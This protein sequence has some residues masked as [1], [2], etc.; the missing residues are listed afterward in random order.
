[1]YKQHSILNT[2]NFNAD[3]KLLTDNRYSMLNGHFLRQIP[4]SSFESIF[5]MTDMCNIAVNRNRKCFASVALLLNNEKKTTCHIL[6]Y[7]MYLL[8]QFRRYMAG[9][10]LIR[11]K[12]Q[13][14]QSIN[15]SK[16]TLIHMLPYK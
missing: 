10:L 14:N 11:R 6:M 2:G 15:L 12:T 8:N 4:P 9:I 3:F 7:L 5:N 13:N 1:M 16:L